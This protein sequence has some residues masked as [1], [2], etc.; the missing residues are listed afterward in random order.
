MV[1][2]D[3]DNR[4]RVPQVMQPGNRRQ[5]Y[6]GALPL[7]YTGVIPA[8]GLEPATTRLGGEVTLV[9]TTGRKFS[10]ALPHRR[11]LDLARPPRSCN[12][13]RGQECPRY[14]MQI[15]AREQ[16]DTEELAP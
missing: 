4:I 3:S 8:A 16:V 7:S 15:L 14:T 10:G 9:F 5:R 12:R 11:R 2:A 6:V 1:R 13:L